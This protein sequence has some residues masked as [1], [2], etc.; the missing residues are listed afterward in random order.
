MPGAEKAGGD[1]F[2]ILRGLKVGT[3]GQVD[4]GDPVASGRH[5]C[6]PAGWSG[7]TGAPCP[8]CEGQ[9]IF[10][11]KIQNSGKSLCGGQA[12]AWAISA[13]VAALTSPI[14]CLGKIA[15]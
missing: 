14:E 5:G 8:V 2:M 6:A 3:A 7:R 12:G 13:R 9:T 1:R 4:L 10:I 11:G 15:A